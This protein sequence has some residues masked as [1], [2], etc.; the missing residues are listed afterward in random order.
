M[1]LQLACSGDTVQ[2]GEGDKEQSPESTSGSV[3]SP[4][5]DSAQEPRETV[6]EK[7]HKSLTWVRLKGLQADSK[8]ILQFSRSN[9]RC[10]TRKSVLVGG[11][12]PRLIR[13]DYCPEAAKP[14]SAWAEGGDL[15]DKPHRATPSWFTPPQPRRGRRAGVV[16]WIEWDQFPAGGSSM[17]LR[18][19]RMR[20]SILGIPVPPYDGSGT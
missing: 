2:H 3:P 20:G 15:E 4:V 13:Q 1:H 5:P 14:R 7:S 9:P 16:S 11:R 17:E 10:S 12:R 6:D 19:R 8:F 18:F